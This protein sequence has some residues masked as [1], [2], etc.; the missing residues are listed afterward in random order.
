MSTLKDCE[1]PKPVDV[2][3]PSHTGVTPAGIMESCVKAHFVKSLGFMRTFLVAVY[4]K[5]CEQLNLVSSKGPFVRLHF[6]NLI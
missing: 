1:E 6:N 3:Q 5:S 4:K 2:S